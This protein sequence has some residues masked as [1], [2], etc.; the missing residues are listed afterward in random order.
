M[1]DMPIYKKGRSSAADG[2]QSRRVI[3]LDDITETSMFVYAMAVKMSLGLGLG[4]GV[5]VTLVGA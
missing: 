4:L 2:Q 1:F 5:R 3:C